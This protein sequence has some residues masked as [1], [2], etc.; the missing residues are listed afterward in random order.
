MLRFARELG[1][2]YRSCLKL[3]ALTEF[4]FVDMLDIL[5]CMKVQS[6]IRSSYTLTVAYVGR[7]VGLL[8]VV[9]L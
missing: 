8:Q 7:C 6:V 9:L 4:L 2:I 1:S 3:R 5:D